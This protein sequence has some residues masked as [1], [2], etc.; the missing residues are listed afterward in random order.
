MS[1]KNI[2]NEKL[3]DV[4][5]GISTKSYQNANCL[6]R[7][8]P[9]LEYLLGD[10]R[11]MGMSPRFYIED[12][13]YLDIQFHE[14]NVNKIAIPMLCFC[15]IPLKQLKNHYVT[16]GSYGIALSKEWGERNKI[17][18]VH[19]LYEN[20]DVFEEFR[21]LFNYA[22]KNDDE[23][24]FNYLFNRLIFTKPKAGFQEKTKKL[25]TDEQEHRYIPNLFTCDELEQFYINPSFL[26][27]DLNHSIANDEK[28]LLSFHTED[29]KYIVVESNKEK[30]NVAN[31]ILD[32]DK[33]S[34]QE[35]TELV[36]KIISIEE[37]EDDF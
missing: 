9:K 25:F 34:K 16:Y 11:K 8:M 37:I 6:I 23:N 15:D 26:L 5:V 12:F 36:T 10:L 4:P 21:E 19:Y 3:H 1:R 18:P 30:N 2:K 28:Y 22:N 13:D 24:I 33:L 29:V 7:C 14:K 20:S 32:N 31:V 35:K 17:A 27:A